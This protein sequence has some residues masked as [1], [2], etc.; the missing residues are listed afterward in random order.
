MSL[1]EDNK[2][3]NFYSAINTPE[4]EQNFYYGGD[5][6]GAIYSKRETKFSLWAPLA[7][8][9]ILKVEKENGFDF[10]NMQ[11]CENGVF[12]ITVKGNLLEKKYRYLVTNNGV[13]NE[14]NDP[15][16]KGASLNSEYSVV[17]D[18]SKL[19]KKKR[20]KPKNAINN[21][22]DAVIYETNV[23]D[24]TEKCS[25]IKEKGKF[26]GFV[27]SGKKTS[28]GYPVGVDY[29]KFLGI[30]HVQLNPI[31]DFANVPD[32][33]T[34]KAYNWGYDP[35]SMFAIEGSYS[36]NPSNASSRLFELSNM[37]EELHKNNI[38]V[39]VDVVY[40]HTFKCETSYYE[41]I[42][43]G[44]FFRKT[45]EGNLANASGCGNDI[46]SE[47]PMV[48]KMIVDS[49]KYLVTY[50][51]IDGFRFDLMGL[52]DIDTINEI[53]TECRKIKKDLMFYGEGWD[54]GFELPFE[55]KACSTN[56]HLMPKVGF[57]N[58]T[59][60]DV[61]KGPNF[62]DRIH[63][64]GYI[65]GDVMY[66]YGMD[67]IFFSG[68]KDISYKPRFSDANQSIIY[69]ECH[70]NHTLFDK[71][72]KSNPEDSEE[73]LLQRVMLANSIIC[74]S[75]GIPFFHSGQEIGMSKCG[76]DN[77]YN[78]LD[79]NSLNWDLIDERFDMVLN[80]KEMVLIRKVL[81][82]TKLHSLKEIDDSFKIE[83][84]KNGLYYLKANNETISHPF[85]DL[86][87]VF[88]PLNK[89]EIIELDNE[90]KLIQR[91]NNKSESPYK[92]HIIQGISTAVFVR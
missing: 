64:K 82:F 42:V 38:R 8:E 12:R 31:L 84:M 73:I 58:D 50:F 35:I 37:I 69:A 18:Y 77:T 67:Y 53:V 24:F 76:N 43:P 62:K 63:E 56:H 54:M 40:N 59:Y 28:K 13:T 55:K 49:A 3:I 22:V 80:L 14:S 32:D 57:F 1:N 65:N 36:S 4:L 48:R 71:L 30:T 60:R 29:L 47:K 6:L 45:K 66:E 21:Y 19:L 44:Y 41:K 39:V 17:V 61:I 75:Y 83:H 79:A 89:D 16:G 15:Y 90:Y 88:N 20:F 92:K 25:S 52:I 85:K 87:I 46:A 34:S 7:S 78:V 10:L 74:L 11:R 27:E 33:D 70:D 9:V 2:Q 72:L 91:I 81:A 26:L 86:I 23:R 68:V 5:D 51:N